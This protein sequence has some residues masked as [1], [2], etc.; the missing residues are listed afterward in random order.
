MEQLHAAPP[1]GVTY[2]DVLARKLNPETLAVW[3]VLSRHVDN[4]TAV[5]REILG[6]VGGETLYLPVVRS[7]EKPHAWFRVRVGDD[8]AELAEGL[9]TF[10]SPHELRSVAAQ[11]LDEV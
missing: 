9:E 5:L 6:E 11:P 3:D 1:R 7:A 4:P 8:L 10:S 2:R